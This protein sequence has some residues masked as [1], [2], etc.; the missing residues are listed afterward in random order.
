MIDNKY[1]VVCGFGCF[2]YNVQCFSDTQE[3]ILS[4]LGLWLAF[5]G[6]AYFIRDLIKGGK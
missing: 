1:I 4:T 6:I 3:L 5:I 2:V